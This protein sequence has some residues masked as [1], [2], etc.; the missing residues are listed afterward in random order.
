M[1]FDQEEGHDEVGPNEVVPALSV[2][3]RFKRV[4]DSASAF[5]QQVVSMLAAIQPQSSASSAP[6]PPPCSSRKERRRKLDSI[7]F[8]PDSSLEA[9][10]GASEGRMPFL[11]IQLTRFAGLSPW[12]RKRPRHSLAWA[13]RKDC[14][15]ICSL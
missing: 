10:F 14:F 4:D 2:E 8:H 7:S 5:Q 3:E 1:P 9:S 12:M 15:P 6:T 11:E 13:E